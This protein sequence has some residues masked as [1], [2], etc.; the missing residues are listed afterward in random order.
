VQNSSAH[1][2]SAEKFGGPEI[3]NIN[4]RGIHIVI[5]S[6]A[7]LVGCETDLRGAN[8]SFLEPMSAAGSYRWKTFADPTFPIDSAKAEAAR[9]RQLGEVLNM[10]KACPRGYEVQDRKATMKA[11]GPIGDTYDMFYTVK[12]S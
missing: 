5:A 2:T 9:L 10:N 8:G 6:L 11:S 7:F 12:C 3:G 1:A 4:V